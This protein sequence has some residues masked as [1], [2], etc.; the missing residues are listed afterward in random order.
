MSMIRLIVQ[1]LG[2]VRL[3]GLVLSAIGNLN[4][5][6]QK[7]F[8]LELK[9]SFLEK[10]VRTGLIVLFARW[11]SLRESLVACL[12]RYSQLL[13]EIIADRLDYQALVFPDRPQAA[14]SA[15]ASFPS[16]GLPNPQTVFA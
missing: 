6:F 2:L 7:G 8:L 4:L 13:M 10:Q 3:I 16:L 1:V 9:I 15:L 14:R 11:Y 5:F 12:L